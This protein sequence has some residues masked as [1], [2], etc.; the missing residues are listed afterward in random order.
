MSG[1]KFADIDMNL[2]FGFLEPN[3]RKI[4]IPFKPGR[5]RSNTTRSG[6]SSSQSLSPSRPSVASPITTIPGMEIA[7]LATRSRSITWSSITTIR[8]WALFIYCSVKGLRFGCY[9][10]LV[11]R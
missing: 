5:K 4:S 2:V 7:I 9:R 3:W 1:V 6:F 11:L 10:F 8:V